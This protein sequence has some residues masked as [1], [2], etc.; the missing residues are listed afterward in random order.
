MTP[1]ISV[2]IIAYNRARFLP[3]AIASVFAQSFIDWE[4]ILVDDGSTDD[5]AAVIRSYAEKDKRIHCFFNEKNLGICQTRARGL[6]EAKGEFAAVL[7]SD[8][9][10]SDQDK[11]KKQVE[12]LK[13]QPDYVMVG[14]G[15]VIT[16]E[17]GQEIKRYLNTTSAEKIR[18]SLLIKNPFAHSTV[19]YRRAV[20]NEVGGY[21]EKLD[22]KEIN[23]I[24]DY[25]LWLKLGSKGKMANLPE[26]F[27]YYRSHP[28]NVSV[29]KRLKL[30]QT[31]LVLIRHYRNDYPFFWLAWL[32]RTTRLHLYQ[33]YN[34][35]IK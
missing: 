1:V 14:G 23:A 18:L 21:S 7:D 9:V 13:I 24:E 22:G 29:Q 35:F 20:A 28:G 5:T 31:T 15:V 17:A 32:R 34:F 19:M 2:I 16:N 27:V 6:A 30:M 12:F 26:Y 8:D 4:L 3:E 11:L 25:E 33:I 10:W